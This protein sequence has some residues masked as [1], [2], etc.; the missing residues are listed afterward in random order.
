MW[1][2]SPCACELQRRVLVQVLSGSAHGDGEHALPWRWS[3]ILECIEL[4]GR[5]IATGKHFTSSYATS[6]GYTLFRPSKRGPTLSAHPSPTPTR[7]LAVDDTSKTGAAPQ[8]AVACDFDTIMPALRDSDR[9]ISL[10][11][12]VEKWSFLLLR[13][14]RLKKRG[15]RSPTLC[16]RWHGPNSNAPLRAR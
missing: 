5:R 12:E 10:L 1:G 8:D 4:Q 6:D 3:H 13:K 2:V 16:T 15:H 9:R 11:K 7:P 14:A